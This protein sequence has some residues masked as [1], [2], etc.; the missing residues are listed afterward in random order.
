MKDIVDYEE[1]LYNIQIGKDNKMF[2]SYLIGLL[3]SGNL[4][5]TI[6]AFAQTEREIQNICGTRIVAV[7]SNND[8]GMR[9]IIKET[10]Q[11]NNKFNAC[12]ENLIRKR[13]EKEAY[14]AILPGETIPGMIINGKPVYKCSSGLPC[15]GRIMR[16]AGVK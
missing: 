10:K 7:G 6:S 4:F 1:F 14:D 5:F 9:E 16:E 3:I 11:K 8:K 15:I 2:V 13:M 12:V